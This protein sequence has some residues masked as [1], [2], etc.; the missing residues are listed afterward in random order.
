MRGLSCSTQVFLAACE[1]PSGQQLAT[2]VSLTVCTPEWTSLGIAPWWQRDFAR[3]KK[4]MQSVRVPC[5][6]SASWNS[7]DSPEGDYSR[8]GGRENDLP[9]T[10][11][12]RPS[13]PTCFPQRPL[14]L[15]HS[16]CEQEQAPP[17]GD[18]TQPIGFARWGEADQE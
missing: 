14:P 3:R 7:K 13:E 10:P 15:T 8:R 6:A 2:N 1:N 4:M 5:C 16:H 11:Q 17:F 18:F 9:Y 12:I